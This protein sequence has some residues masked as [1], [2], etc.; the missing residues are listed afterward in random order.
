MDLFQKTRVSPLKLHQNQKVFMF[1]GE[2]H[3]FLGGSWVTSFETDKY[4]LIDSGCSF[5]DV[6]H[7]VTHVELLHIDMLAFL[8]TAMLVLGCPRKGKRLGSVGYSPNICK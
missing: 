1:F 4:R 6:S 5:G 8:M 7:T 2:D 3:F